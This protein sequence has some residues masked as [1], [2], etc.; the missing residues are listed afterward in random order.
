MPAGLEDLALEAQDS[1]GELELPSGIL[2]AELFTLDSL[3]SAY[4]DEAGS[5][6]AATDVF[7]KEPEASLQS[8]ASF[9]LPRGGKRVR[10]RGLLLVGGTYDVVKQG[11]W[12]ER[13]GAEEGESCVICEGRRWSTSGPG[14]SK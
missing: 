12:E 11:R 8:L 3:A 7:A 9:R 6:S 5:T 4:E 10:V 13:Q 1:D 2:S 14:L